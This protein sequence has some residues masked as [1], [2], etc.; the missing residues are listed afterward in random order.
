MSEKRLLVVDDVP[1]LGHLVGAV[2]TG[3]GYEVKVVTSAQ[4]FMACIDDFNPTT[5]VLDIVMPEMDGLQLIK[6]LRDRG[7]DAKVFVASADNLNYATLGR[8][9]GRSRGLNISVIPKPFDNDE[10][11]EALS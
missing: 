2:A 1:E 7:C 6:W 8:N 3:L 10:L 5:L 9:L 11:V 4:E